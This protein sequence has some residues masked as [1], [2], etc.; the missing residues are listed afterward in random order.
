MEILCRIEMY[1]MEVG[2]NLKAVIALSI[3]HRA[4]VENKRTY[5]LYKVT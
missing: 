1:S 4:N 3:G 2:Q 5:I